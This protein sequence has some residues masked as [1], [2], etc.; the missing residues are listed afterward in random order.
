MSIQNYLD[1][2]SNDIIELDLSDRNLT[3]LPNL[4]RFYKLTRLNIS[5]NKLKELI[6]IP[7]RLKELNCSNNNIINIVSL[8]LSLEVFN[9]QFN[10]LKELPT[11]PNTLKVFNC[12]YNEIIILPIIP[13]RLKI[14]YCSDNILTELPLLPSNLKI[15]ECSYNCITRLPIIPND[16][17]ELYCSYNELIILPLIPNL[18]DIFNYE[19]NPIYDLI[20]SNDINI[21]NKKCNIIRNFIFSYNVFKY[22][23]QFKNFYYKKIV[24]PRIK[25]KGNPEYLIKL[26][27]ENPC[28]T[29]EEVINSFE[30][31][32]I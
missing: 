31:S 4:I 15:L 6:N 32:I 8:P 25:M 10:K 22:K 20:N 27:E 29:L 26:I 3:E 16:I 14:F 13:D 23:K 9:C 11:L 21:I 2:L 17:E 28:K 12:S 24:E 30:N 18:I 5:M 19:F 1:I 7:P